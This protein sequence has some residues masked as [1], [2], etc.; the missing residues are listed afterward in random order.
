MYILNAV[1]NRTVSI[2]EWISNIARYHSAIEID[3]FV[4]LESKRK[5]EILFSIVSESIDR[6]LY[7]QQFLNAQ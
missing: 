6:P 7:P 4:R 2:I 5:E 1:Y 3:I